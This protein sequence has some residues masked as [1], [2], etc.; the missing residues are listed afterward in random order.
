MKI[1]SL[2]LTITAVS[3]KEGDVYIVYCPSLDISGYDMSEEK[4]KESFEV[5]IKEYI[6]YCMNNNTL[7]E[8]LEKHGWTKKG[9]MP[10]NILVNKN[11]TLKDI[12]DNNNFSKFTML[13]PL[14]LHE[15]IQA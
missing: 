3:F 7:E 12:V 8:D 11:D 6:R 15:H 10:F 14:Q 4:A 5:A 13:L 2:E 9:E 1:N